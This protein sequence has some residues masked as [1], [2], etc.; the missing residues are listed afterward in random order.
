MIVETLVEVANMSE[1]SARRWIDNGESYEISVDSFAKRIKNMWTS[2]RL[3]IIW[4]SWLMKWGNLSLM[5]STGM[6]DL[7][8]IV[9]DLGNIRSE[10]VWV[11]VTSQQDIDELEKD[12]HSSQDFSKIQ[13]RFNTRLSLS[14]ANAD[15]VIK[16]RLLEKNDSGK[17]AV[18]LLYTSEVKASLRNKI[19]F[20]DGTISLK[21]YDTLKDF[22]EFYPMIPYQWICYSSIHE[23]P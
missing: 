18:Q 12:I 19:N 8:T 7:Q 4:F 16:K 14:S 13:G 17:D 21:K 1:E 5:M 15:E 9:E 22:S 20:S 23:N 3:T 6:L 10:K 11:I 2:S